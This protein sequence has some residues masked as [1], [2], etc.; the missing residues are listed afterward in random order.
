MLEYKTLQTVT[1]HLTL[2]LLLGFIFW[3]CEEEAED[4]QIDVEW[5]SYIPSDG[6]QYCAYTNQYRT[7]LIQVY[8][9]EGASGYPE[10]EVP[11]CDNF[12]PRESVLYNKVEDLLILTSYVENWITD[13]EE[14][15]EEEI[16]LTNATDIQYSAR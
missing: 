3:S 2:L 1:K 8:G 5:L 10:S 11:Q 6:V 14:L 9:I 12:E 15:V 16:D 13:E 4:I 7:D